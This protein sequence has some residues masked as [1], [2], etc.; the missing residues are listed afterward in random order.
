MLSKVVR[1][2]PPTTASM[3]KFISREEDFDR[4]VTLRLLLNEA[5][6]VPI[7]ATFNADL[8]DTDDHEKDFRDGACLQGFS[9]YRFCIVMNV[10][11]IDL[12]RMLMQQNLSENPDELKRIFKQIVNA[13][14]H[15]H[16]CGV[17]H[18]D[19]SPGNIVQF[20][21]TMRLLDFDG[22]AVIGRRN[23]EYA[24]AKFSSAYVPPE[25]LAELQSGEV[26]VRSKQQAGAQVDFEIVPASAAIDLWA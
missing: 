3:L 23:V 8:V 21:G 2:A 25:M 12:K 19:L 26:V 4:E 18:G 20:E 15:I 13:V 5:F 17:M 6:T 16:L 14:K 22:A 1:K 7:I 11:T 10:A 9:P 24:G